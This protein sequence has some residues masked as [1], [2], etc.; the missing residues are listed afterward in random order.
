[1]ATGTIVIS[2]STINT[3]ADYISVMVRDNKSKLVFL[4][5][6]SLQDFATAI[7][8]QMSICEFKVAY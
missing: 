1:M 5:E 2:R 4:C 3:E 7:T 8:G 6:L